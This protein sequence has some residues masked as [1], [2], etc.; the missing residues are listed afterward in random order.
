VLV[1]WVVVLCETVGRSFS[2]PKD[3]GSMFPQNVGYQ[4]GVT[5]QKTNTEIFTAMRTLFLTE[6]LSTL[7]K[8]S[9]EEGQ[10]KARKVPL[11]EQKMGFLLFEMEFHCPG[12]Q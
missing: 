8:Q 4:H 9:T 7:M 5:T 1:F 12:I 10:K 2:N 3:E 6:V 11:V